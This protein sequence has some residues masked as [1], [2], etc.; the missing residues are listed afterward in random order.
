MNNDK[1]TEEMESMLSEITEL[2]F[3]LVFSRKDKIIDRALTVF[4]RSEQ[5]AK[6]YLATDGVRTQKEIARYL[7]TYP[8][9]VSPHI[10]ELENAGL[11]RPEK[12]VQ[13]GFIYGKSPAFEQIG[14]SKH[15]KSKFK[16]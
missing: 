16:L 1:E 6:V 2:L 4:G 3:L 7:E 10:T 12:P 15:L 11:I 13:G 9:S 14:L 5:R 8:S